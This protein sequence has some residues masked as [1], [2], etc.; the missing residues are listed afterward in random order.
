[1]DLTTIALLTLA[2]TLAGFVDAIAGGG[3]LITLPA[4]LL[5]GASPAEAIATNKLQ[6]TF[7]VAAAS[8]SYA[9]A[10]QINFRSLV[11]AIIATAIGAALGAIA[12]TLLDPS[13]LRPFIPYALI[14][15]ALYFALAP[16]LR[17][18][19]PRVPLSATAFAVGLAAPVGFY[20]G[21][22]GP[23]AGSL[24]T[25][26]FVAFAGVNLL[27]ATAHTKVLNL[28]SNVMSLIVFLVSGNVNFLLGVP[29]AVGQAAGAWAGSHTALRHGTW[30]IRPLLVVTTAVAA[31]KL[32]FSS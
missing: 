11:P 31:L 2:A 12:V 13:L 14:A 24:Y 20:D 26:A 16:Y 15:A 23:G 25:L 27:T 4:L 19:A 7:G 28:T 29:M 5:A 32:W 3:G 17:E 6:G 21:L 22:F 10:G 8:V 1:M 18:R 30:L 9:R